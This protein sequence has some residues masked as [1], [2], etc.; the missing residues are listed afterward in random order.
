[1]DDTEFESF[2]NNSSFKPCY[3]WNTFN[4]KEGGSVEWLGFS[5][6]PCYKWN[7]FNT[8]FISEEGLKM[9]EVL[10]LVINGIPSIQNIFKIGKN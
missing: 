1:M 10:N 4:T 2:C 6:K 5:F 7:T 3:K 8:I 9:I